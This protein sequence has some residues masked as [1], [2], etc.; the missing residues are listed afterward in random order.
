M[1]MN[2]VFEKKKKKKRN[3]KENLVFNK[4]SGSVYHICTFS[5]QSILF[6]L[7]IKIN[8]PSTKINKPSIL[9]KIYI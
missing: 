3:S 5:F 9:Q 2:F 6:E 7:I 8:E 4:I 1:S